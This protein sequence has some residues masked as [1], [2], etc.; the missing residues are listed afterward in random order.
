MTYILF[1]FA[2]ILGLVFKKSKIC[3][4]YMLTVM[5]FLAALRTQ[6][7]DLENYQVEYLYGYSSRYFGFDFFTGVFRTIGFSFEQYM[8]AFYI[9]TYM[10]LFVA[11]RLLTQNVNFTLACYMIYS[12]G[13][14]AIQMKTCISNVFVLLSFSI[15]LRCFEDKKK[16][17]KKS[18]MLLS[19]LL[20]LF[21]VSLHLSAVYYIVCMVTYLIFYN[22]PNMSIKAIAIVICLLLIINGGILPWILNVFSNL[23]IIGGMDYFAK[24]TAKQTSLGFFIPIINIIIIMFAFYFKKRGDSSFPNGTGFAISYNTMY[25]CILS[26]WT[27]VPI[28]M[29][30]LQY[31]RLFHPFYLLIYIFFSEKFFVA[32]CNIYALLSK[33][34]FFVL[35]SFVFIYELP[36]YDSTLGAL[37]KY[38]ALLPGL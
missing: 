27:I 36:V 33:I 21:G 23:G 15:V 34:L 29:I 8:I 1:L 17:T 7:A 19:A 38:N 13:I 12:Y 18:L 16:I 11:I 14:D 6:S 24:F 2:I 4:A 22:R 30:N 3:S 32:K 35:I 31:Y 9:I 28:M 26:M 37:L 25:P 5:V 20:M 10:L